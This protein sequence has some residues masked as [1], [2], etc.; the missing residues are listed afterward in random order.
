MIIRLDE[1]GRCCGRKPLDYKSRWSTREGP[2]RY[3]PRCDR[4]YDR[5]TGEQM[6]NWAFRRSADGTAF[7]RIS[8]GDR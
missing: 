6:P 3:C 5:D 2:Q 8:G 7:V 1:K 4:A